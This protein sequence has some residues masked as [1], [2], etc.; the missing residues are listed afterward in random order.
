MAPATSTQ[1]DDTI[2]PI[3]RG[4]QQRLRELLPGGKIT[5]PYG[6]EAKW[7]SGA[8][9]IPT[10][11]AACLS[12]AD[13]TFRDFRLRCHRQRES[14]SLKKVEAHML[15]R[16]IFYGAQVALLT[17]IIGCS[18]DSGTTLTNPGLLKG[19]VSIGPLCP[20]QI[21]GDQCQPSPDLYTSHHIIVLSENGN[22]VVATAPISGDGSYSVELNAGTYTI[23]Y[24][25]HDIGIPGSFVP[26]K[27]AVEADKTTVLDIHIDTGIR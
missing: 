13:A 17:C 2:R 19:T 14:L 5:P 10:L 20:A 23:D 11:P 18:G 6:P 21:P 12:R 25:P 16:K 3:T 24:G 4:V 1:E 8:A 26:L 22:S 15:L 7:S 9:E 27:T